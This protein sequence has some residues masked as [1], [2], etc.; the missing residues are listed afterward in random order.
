MASKTHLLTSTVSPLTVLS[1]RWIVS[2]LA[3]TGQKLF[4]MQRFQGITAYLPTCHSTAGEI[5][6][7]KRERKESQIS[8]HS[9]RV[10]QRDWFLQSKWIYQ[11]T[12]HY[13]FSLEGVGDR[14]P[15]S[16]K[17]K[18]WDQIAS[19]YLKWCTLESMG[20]Q[21][22]HRCSRWEFLIYPESVW[23]KWEQFLQNHWLCLHLK[24]HM[25]TY[26]HKYSS[27]QS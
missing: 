9:G 15:I 14:H 26:T 10:K 24:R 2:A 1:R 22:T 27:L 21:E 13:E 11:L 6:W 17:Y 25:H 18:F 4:G 5:A 23:C 7:V 16:A 19:I 20:C 12:E 3:L 8:I